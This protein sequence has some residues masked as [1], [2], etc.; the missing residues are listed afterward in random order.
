MPVKVRKTRGGY[1]VTDAGRVTARRTTKTKAAAQARLLRGVA[2]G[3][4]PS[5]KR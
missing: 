2:R 4:K 1:R 5:R 3:W